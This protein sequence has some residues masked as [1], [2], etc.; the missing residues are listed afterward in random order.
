[1]LQT[2][3]SPSLLVSVSSAQG[4]ECGPRLGSEEIHLLPAREEAALAIN[5][6]PNRPAVGPRTFP[7]LGS[8][9]LS[10]TRLGCAFG[11]RGCSR[12]RRRDRNRDGSPPPARAR[13]H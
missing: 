13:S 2:W 6:Q 10:S 9:S 1:M 3:H 11:P 4:S 7:P 12:P 5:G 8:G